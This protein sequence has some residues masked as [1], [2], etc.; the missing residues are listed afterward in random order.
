MRIRHL[1]IA[2]LVVTLAAPATA[3]PTKEYA[4][5]LVNRA[6]RHLVLGPHVGG[7]L[8]F[9]PSDGSFSGG[10]CFGL[11]VYL[12][13]DSLLS[14]GGM[15]DAAI[16]R[17]KARKSELLEEAKTLSDADRA[18]ARAEADKA[19][20][21]IDEEIRRELAAFEAVPAPSKIFQL[22][23]VILDGSWQVRLSTGVFGISKI[24]IGP[25][26]AVAHSDGGTTILLGPELSF[27]YLIGQG[28]RTPV[29]EVFL[30]YDFATF[31]RDVFAD[32]ASL[33]VRLAL[34]IL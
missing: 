22:E 29:A 24:A 6:R 25:T 15:K 33:G 27:N 32:T 17:L 2:A 28:L 31:N 10:G 34:D 5:L 12:F 14:L 9:A 7:A 16:E 3:S 20:A 1:T 8:T 11:G 21:E 4:R 23:G 13:T 30:R 18:A 26:V 19:V